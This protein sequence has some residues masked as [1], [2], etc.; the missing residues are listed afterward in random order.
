MSDAVRTN[1]QSADRARTGESNERGENIMRTSTRRR[2]TKT[3]AFTEPPGARGY[4]ELRATL[5][6]T[7][8]EHAGDYVYVGVVGGH[9][10]FAPATDEPVVYL[11]EDEVLSF[12]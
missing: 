9:H 5:D 2:R 10:A 8:W 4:L 1:R 11:R 3:E 12:R 7:T 6:D